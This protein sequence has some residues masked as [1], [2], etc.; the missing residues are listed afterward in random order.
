MNVLTIRVK[1]A[2][3]AST[4]KEAIDAHAQAPTRES[5]ATKVID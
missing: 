3:N 2:P 4:P 5:I 1:M